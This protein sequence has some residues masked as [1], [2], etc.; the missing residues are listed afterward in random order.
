MVTA[1]PEWLEDL[2]AKVNL[3]WLGHAD[4]FRAWEREAGWVADGEAAQANPDAD[5]R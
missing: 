1:M 3:P 4:D 5:V 2:V